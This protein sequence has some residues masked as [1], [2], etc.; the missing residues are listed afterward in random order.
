MGCLRVCAVCG[1]CLFL[2]SLLSSFPPSLSPP[3]H[4]VPLLAVAASLSDLY[5]GPRRQA[6][7]FTIHARLQ[8]LM[9]KFVVAVAVTTPHCGRVARWQG[10]GQCDSV[11]VRQW[12]TVVRQSQSLL[13]SS[14]SSQWRCLVAI[15]LSFRFGKLFFRLPCAPLCHTPLAFV[16][17]IIRHCWLLPAACCLLLALC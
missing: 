3:H 10:G 12:G 1:V 2:F 9:A 15:S 7:T 5:P 8:Y 17:S 16:D 14:Y 11:A 4:L 6:D 13:S